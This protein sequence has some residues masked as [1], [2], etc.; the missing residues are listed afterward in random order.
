MPGCCGRSV[1]PTLTGARCPAIRCL[2]QVSAG[3]DALRTTEPRFFVLRAKSYGR[4]PSFLLR[5]GW[6]R[7]DSVVAA[8]AAELPAAA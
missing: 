3:V 4:T 5:I 8:L 2:T 7:V 1:V 6:E